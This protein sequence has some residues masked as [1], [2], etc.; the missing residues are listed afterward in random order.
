MSTFF[1]VFFI[2]HILADALLVY[3]WIKSKPTIQAL[4]ETEAKLKL[5][6]ATNAVIKKALPKSKLARLGILNKLSN[7]SSKYE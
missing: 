6:E 5:Q 3:R 2:V 1:I 7:G 4:A